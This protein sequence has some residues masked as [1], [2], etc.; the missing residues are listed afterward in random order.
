MA[1]YRYDPQAGDP[2]GFYLEDNWTAGVYQARF[3]TS[4][5]DI[6]GVRSWET[7]QE[8]LDF[9]APLG[10]T[11]GAKYAGARVWP[12]LIKGSN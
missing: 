5:T 2:T 6:R 8:F 7:R 12:V 3:G 4:F 9:V 11:L 1:T 10:W